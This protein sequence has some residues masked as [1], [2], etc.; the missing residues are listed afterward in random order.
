MTKEI[1]EENFPECIFMFKVPNKCE[2]GWKRHPLSHKLV[3]HQD[4]E[5]ILK[6]SEKEKGHL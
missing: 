2:T 6:T 1:I 4:K 3:T 5:K